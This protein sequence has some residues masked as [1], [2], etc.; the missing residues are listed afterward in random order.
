MKRRSP[1]TT[2]RSAEPLRILF[3]ENALGT[4]EFTLEHCERACT[5]K[6]LVSLAQAGP[7]LR[8][9]LFQVLIANDTERDPIDWNEMRKLQQEFPSVEMVV[10]TDSGETGSLA[11]ED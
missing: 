10:L 6:R 7:F 2:E 3:I 9:S 5:I 4:T 11:E 8:T 1:A